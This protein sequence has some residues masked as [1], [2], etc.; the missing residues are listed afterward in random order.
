MES[1][2]LHSI[3]NSYGDIVELDYRFSNDALFQVQKLQNWIDG[4]NGKQGLNL[5]GPL[6][7]LRLDAP[8]DLKHLTQQSS[9]VNLDTCPELKV[10]FDL[11]TDLSICRAV[12]MNTGS[13]FRLHRDA[14][15]ISDQFRIFIPLNKTDL[16]EWMFV[17]ETQ[18][19]N[20][21]P[22][23][24]YILNTRKSHG[25]FAM[26]DDIYHILMSVHL[27]KHNIRQIANLLPNCN[28]N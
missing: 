2:C 21:K 20:F 27:N 9:N 4:A 18:V 8:K 28:D 6:D 10:F 1:Q 7:D 25:S 19:I 12:R 15:K 16:S 23:V 13:F 24:P 3:L 5:T 22:G 14:Y 26:S 17:Y 11:W